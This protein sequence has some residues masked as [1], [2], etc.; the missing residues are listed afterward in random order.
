[1]NNRKRPLFAFAG[2]SN[3]MGAPVYETSEQIY[4]KNSFEYLHKKRR[5][6]IF[7]PTVKISFPV[8][9]QVKEFLFGFRARVTE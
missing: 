8:M 6:V 2:Q 3:M 4:F 7:L 9:T 5:F 1:M